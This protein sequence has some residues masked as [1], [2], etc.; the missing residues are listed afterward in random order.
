LDVRTFQQKV[1]HSKRESGQF[2][3]NALAGYQCLT[4]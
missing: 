3:P 1:S 4:D 2:C